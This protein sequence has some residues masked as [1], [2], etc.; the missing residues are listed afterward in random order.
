MENV[1][2]FTSDMLQVAPQPGNSKLQMGGLVCCFHQKLA[3]WQLPALHKLFPI[4]KLF[5]SICASFSAKSDADTLLFNVCP[6][7]WTLKL[8][9]QQS[10]CV[11]NKTQQLHPLQPY[12]KHGKCQQSTVSVPRGPSS[13]CCHLAAS[14]QTIWSHHVVF[15]FLAT[16]TEFLIYFPTLRGNNTACVMT[17]ISIRRI[18]ASEI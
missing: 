13:C 18:S 6:L 17:I 12:I 5:R 8:Q 7:L 14:Q 16:W 9:L 2:S 3:S 4:F 15:L 1:L 11:L 10:T